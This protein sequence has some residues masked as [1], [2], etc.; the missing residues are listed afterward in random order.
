MSFVT[1]QPNIRHGGHRKEV[2]ISKGGFMTLSTALVEAHLPRAEAV[3]LLYDGESQRIAVKPVNRNADN[4]MKLAVPRGSR[5][6]R[7]SASGFLEFCGIR[8]TKS[9]VCP[10]EWDESLG[11]VVFTVK[12]EGGSK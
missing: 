3:H 10:A 4:S 1:Y 7:I 11:A 2:R 6:R 8:L 12:G 5:S 9:L